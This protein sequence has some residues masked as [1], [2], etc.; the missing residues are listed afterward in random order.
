MYVLRG[1]GLIKI[2]GFGGD[3]RLNP[4]L[5]QGSERAQRSAYW[6]GSGAFLCVGELFYFI[7]PGIST[8]QIQLLKSEFLTLFASFSQAM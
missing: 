2:L 6:D 4:P 5:R 7:Q 3:R 1:K 8:Q